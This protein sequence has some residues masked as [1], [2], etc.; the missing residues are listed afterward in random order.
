MYKG[1]GRARSR[2][3][4]HFKAGGN[5]AGGNN[6]RH[7]IAG[8][9]HIIKS[10]QYG[11]RFL[12]FGQQLNGDFGDDGQQPFAAGNQ[13]HQIV[14]HRIQRIGT[15]LHQFTGHGHRTHLQDVV[16]REAVF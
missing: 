7:R 1:F 2:A 6:T 5:N 10:G 4:H 13:R 11:L 15:Q 16:H 3:I 8:F 9:F 12:W 14:S